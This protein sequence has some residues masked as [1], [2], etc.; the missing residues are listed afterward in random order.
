MFDQSSSALDDLERAIDALTA[1][2]QPLDLP[3]LRRCADR[4]DG[5]WHHAVLVASRAGK[6]ETTHMSPAGV[7]AAACRMSFGAAKRT[8]TVAERFEALPQTRAAFLAG[9]ITGDHARVIYDACTAERADALR[10]VEAQLVDVGRRFTARQLLFVV[11]RICD[12]IDGDDGA[13]DA[14]EKYDRRQVF[15]S[16]TLDGIGVLKGTLDPEGTEIVIQALDARMEDDPDTVAEK[17][18]TRPQRRADAIVDICRLYLASI[19]DTD[20]AN[21]RR[22]RPHVSAYIDLQLWEAR[23]L[24][25]L[26]ERVRGDLETVGAVSSAT[27]KRICCDAQVSRVITDGVSVPIDVGR[28]TRTIPDR[29]WRALVARDQHCTFPGC[30]QPPRFCEAHHIEHWADGGPT[31][32]ANLKLLCWRHHWAE[33]E[34]V[35]A[36]G[37]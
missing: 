34:G 21:R 15:L 19:D 9:E 2:E 4:L 35:A 8:L 3:R 33:H 13:R 24:G 17:H 1:T 36:R 29:L 5:A 20:H 7:L 18:R 28:M 37:P 22:G 32:L 25:D 6:L 10:G 23:D 14:N 12:A 30:D 27:L 16:P 11:K 26:A 31:D